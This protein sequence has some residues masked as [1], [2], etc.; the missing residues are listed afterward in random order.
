MLGEPRVRGGRCS[1]AGADPAAVVV[2]RVVPAPQDPVVAGEPVVVELVR[3]RRR[4]PAGCRQPIDVQLAR[5]TAARS[6]ARSRRPARCTAAAGAAATGRRWWRARP[7][8]AA[9]RRRTAC[10]PASPSPSRR[11]RRSPRVCSWIRTPERRGRPG[12]RPQASRAGSSSAVPVAVPERRRGT[13]ASR[14]RRAPRRASSSSTSCPAP[15]SDL[16]HARPARRPGAAAV[17][18]VQLAG[19]LEVAVDAVAGARWSS[20][21]SRFA[22]AEPRPAPPSRRA[23]AGMPLPNPCVRLAGAEAAVAAARR[24]AAGAGLDAAPRH[25]PGSRSLASS[26]VHSPV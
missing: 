8:A 26:A 25:R 23:S 18:T 19:A 14:P 4:C 16:G 3:R 15:V 12:R 13:S 9:D 6:S 17:A 1:S 21:A 10:A 20:I 22:R 24:P 5:R 11:E 7:G 2:E